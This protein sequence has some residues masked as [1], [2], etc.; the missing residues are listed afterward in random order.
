MSY[1]LN[2]KKKKETY[3]AVFFQSFLEVLNIL[4]WLLTVVEF[5]WVVNRILKRISWQTSHLN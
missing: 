2:K 4:P 1:V 3:L 5:S